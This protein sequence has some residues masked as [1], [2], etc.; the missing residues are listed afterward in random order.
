MTRDV[1]RTSLQHHHVL[2]SLGHRR[3]QCDRGGTAADDNHTTP[4]VVEILG[5][6]LRVHDLTA[7]AL[8]TLEPRSVAFGVA[9]VPGAQVQEAATQLM[10]AAGLA[11]MDLDRPALFGARPVSG[12]HFDAV[13]D[14]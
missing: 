14:E 5:P 13:V 1:G 10:I 8:L 3:H 9:V 6:E 7:E 2:R 11:I 12:A 4:C